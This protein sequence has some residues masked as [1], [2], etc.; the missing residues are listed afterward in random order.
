MVI[1]VEIKISS[2]WAIWEALRAAEYE[3]FVWLFLNILLTMVTV[4]LLT[5]KRKAHDS[6]PP[7]VNLGD[8]YG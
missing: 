7:Q 3:R 2:Y 1:Q 8:R 5:I 4:V 6:E